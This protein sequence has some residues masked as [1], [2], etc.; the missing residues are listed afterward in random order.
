GL[1]VALFL[2]WYL[3]REKEG[4]EEKAIEAVR[5]EKA[6]GL[7]K[8][9]LKRPW[10]SIPGTVL[11]ILI[12]VSLIRLVYRHSADITDSLNQSHAEISLAVLPFTNYTGDAE[13]EWL[14]A[15]L[16]ET[17]I[18]ELSKISQVGALRLIS[19]STVSAFKNYNKPVPEIAREINVD[20]LVEA[21]VLGFGDSITLQLR[22]IQVYP[23]ENVVWA[24]S[25]SSN[26]TDVLKLNSGIAGQIAEKMN[27]D[28][29]SEEIKKLPSPRKVNPE[30]YRAYFRGMHHLNLDTPEDKEKGL[31]YLHEAVRIDPGE[32]F[33]YAGLALGYLEIAHGPLGTADDLIKAEAAAN[34]AIKL[35]T[36]MAEIYA[37]KAAVYLYKT[38]EFE[39]AE[40][41]FIKAL[42]LNPNLALTR[43]HYAWALYLFDRMEEGIVENE[44]AQKYDPF[45]PNITAHLGLLYCHDGRHEDAMREAL[46][47][48]E[49][50]KDYNMGYYALGKA[51]LSMGRI[52]DAIEAHK[53]LAELYPRWKW[54][55][56]NTYAISGHRDEAEK[57]LNELEKSEV[58]PF[59]ALGLTIMYGALGKM[60]EA[61]KWLAYEP[62][63]A[64]LPWVAVIPSWSKL[65]HN[66]PRFED[67]LKRLNLPD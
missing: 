34:Q 67:F 30:S 46:K 10:F 52:D 48:L 36:T 53:K 27:L 44:L 17:L 35:D 6:P 9:M 61:F 19:K 29:S 62:H 22:L 59:N 63:S 39:K 37:A 50:A 65:I 66:D 58:N 64:W 28:L 41:Y 56:G 31:E 45:N 16:H 7:F 42:E 8:V 25:C 49:I 21:S 51:Y 12:V 2:S 57:I 32:P 23:E 55:L 43:W 60:D 33:A 15:G 11:F 38:W 18:N 13:Q 47:S 4:A 20:Y 24:E 54:A 1:P 40:R 26:F 14:V 3:S 5:G